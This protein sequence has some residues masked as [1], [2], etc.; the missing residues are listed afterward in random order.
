MMTDWSNIQA[1]CA[2][3]QDKMPGQLIGNIMRR[4]DIDKNDEENEACEIFQMICKKALQADDKVFDAG[5]SGCEDSIQ[6]HSKLSKAGKRRTLREA[7]ILL[8]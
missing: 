8:T 3:M 4:G 5:F 6:I 1:Y 2:E 7:N